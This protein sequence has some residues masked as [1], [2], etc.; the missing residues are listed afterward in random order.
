MGQRP[1]MYLVCVFGI[2]CGLPLCAEHRE[3]LGPSRRVLALFANQVGQPIETVLERLRPAPLDPAARARV[4]AA[5]PRQGA[6]RAGRGE[7]AKMQSAEA[8]LAHEGRTGSISMTIINVAPAFVGLHER[9][10]I[11]TSMQAL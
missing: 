7:L 9:A 10:V 8:L 5:L 11:L 6:V 4:I 3:L 1:A 2:V